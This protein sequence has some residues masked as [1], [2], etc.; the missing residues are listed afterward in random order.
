MEIV[1]DRLSLGLDDGVDDSLDRPHWCVVTLLLPVV[2]WITNLQ[3]E[4]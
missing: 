4:Q 1:K 3:T 2:G